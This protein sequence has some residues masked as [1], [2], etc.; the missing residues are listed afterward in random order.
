MR[1]KQL[2][3]ERGWT[4]NE[5]A[6]KSGVDRGALASIETGKAKNP[7][8]T[9][10]LKL[11]RAFNIRPEELYQA[12]GYI[13]NVKA[14]YPRQE[15]PEQILERL[16]LSQPVS[17][18]VYSDFPF[19]AGEPVEP[20]DYIYRTRPKG[21]PKNIEGYIVAGKSLEPNVK[22]GDIVIVDRDAAIDN[23]DLVASLVDGQL[24]LMHLRKVADEL[25]LENNHGR[26]KFEECQ[27][28]APVIE[29]IRRLK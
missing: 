15:T 11:A 1:L 8:T 26:I 10:I 4:Q 19:H 2:R 25:Y 9:N 21:A 22:N 16:R 3:A 27:V 12:A 18:P 24:R 28:A 17:V 23:G 14:S 5:L 7:T 29:V 20:V 13:G 6:K